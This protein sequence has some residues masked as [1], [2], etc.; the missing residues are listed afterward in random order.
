MELLKKWLDGSINWK[1][2][3]RL[4]TEARKDNFL[5]DAL[6]GLDALPDAD[7]THN[8]KVLEQRLQEHISKKKKRKNFPVR[9]IAAAAIL[10]LSIGIWWNMQNNF[11]PA[12]IAE[13]QTKSV[14]PTASPL[15]ENKIKEDKEEVSIPNTVAAI[16]DKITDDKKALPKEF[17]TT[18]SEKPIAESNKELVVAQKELPKSNTIQSY[19]LQEEVLSSTNSPEKVEI[20]TEASSMVMEVASSEVYS[21]TEQEDQEDAAGI[22]IVEEVIAASPAPVVMSEEPIDLTSAPISMDVSSAIA[23]Q[24]MPV[25]RAMTRRAN[26]TPT[27][28]V[29]PV[30]GM[31]DFRTYLKANKRYPDIANVEGT[32]FLVFSL[33][34]DGTVKDIEVTKSLHPAFDK[35]AIR[36]LK[37]GPKWISPARVGYCEIAF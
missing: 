30:G 19:D 13:R 24:D 11:K 23:E 16:T 17:K 2:E 34:Q 4:R 37:E 7:H 32:V 18:P 26:N 21:I 33:D 12:P 31:E 15:I 20:P 5:A 9:A 25:A 14:S 28:K 36:L 6:D 22:A 29:F 8:T 35:E 27:T 10:L 1:E 3:K